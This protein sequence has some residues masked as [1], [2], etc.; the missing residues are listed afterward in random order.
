MFGK[1]LLFPVS[2]LQPTASL[3]DGGSLHNTETLEEEDI[4]ATI[5]QSHVVSL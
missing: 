2:S 4:R 3:K 5:A 1:I